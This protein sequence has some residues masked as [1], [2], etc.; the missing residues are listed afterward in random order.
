MN[1][2]SYLRQTHPNLLFIVL[3][4]LMTNYMAK[5]S[6]TILPPPNIVIII[7]D[8]QGYGDLASFVPL[9][10]DAGYSAIMSGKEH[11]DNWVPQHCYFAETFEQSFTFWATTEYFVPPD[12]TFERP[13]YLNGKETR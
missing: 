10:R 13:F 5:A 4:L 1:L 3:L 12:G 2:E 9:L 6:D 7:T 11:F 8:D